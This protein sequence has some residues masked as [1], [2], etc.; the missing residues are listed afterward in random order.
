MSKVLANRLKKILAKIIST[1]QI[2]FIPRRLI[3]DN[4]I[5]AYE[6]LHSMKSRYRG[7]E[8]GMA[9]KFDISKAYDRIE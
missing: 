4:I 3:T 2:A 7:K 1:S 8:C 9:L 6:P 5:V